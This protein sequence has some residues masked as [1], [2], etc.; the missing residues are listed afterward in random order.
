VAGA[1]LTAGLVASLLA[2]RVR[3]P[4]LVLFLGLGMLIGS[5]GTGWIDFDD[6]ELSRTIGT[7]A[8]ALILFE[9]GLVSGFREVRPVLRSAISLALVGTLITAVISGF[10]ATWLFDFSLL[11]GLLLGSILA[12]TDAAAIYSVLQGSTL[13]R[14]VAQT[15]EGEA[16]LNDPVAVLL[17][18]G[19]IDWIE[20][21]DYGPID[22]VRLFVGE[23]V[24]GAVIGLGVGWLAA[25]G[26]RRVRLASG[27]LYPVASLA[28]GGLAF[29]A[30]DTLGGSGFLAVYL[31]G[32]VLGTQAIPA[33]RTI[34]AFHGGWR[35]SRSSRCS[36]RS[37][38]S[39]SPVSSGASR[40]RDRSS[41]WSSWSSPGQSL[42]SWPP[43]P[44]AIRP[45]SGLRWGGRACGVPSR[46]SSRLSL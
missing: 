33:R 34:T 35:G 4:A 39:F 38:Y 41:L 1:M 43:W 3:V 22:M 42:H 29:G 10:A 13:R 26:M 9:G 11:E 28:A 8:L 45:V 25:H 5:D 44:I 19:F 17:V 31:A 30:A 7:V 46:W 37:A 18:V 36:S 32:L 27:G 14:K 23:L 16:G 12:A 20:K 15:L 24:I 21:P 6:Y 40:S 2:V